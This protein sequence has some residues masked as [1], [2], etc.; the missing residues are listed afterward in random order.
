MAIAT[1]TILAGSVGCS[2]DWKKICTCV[3]SALVRSKS[4]REVSHNR[5]QLAFE[6]RSLQ[7]LN[8]VGA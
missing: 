6:S 8:W 7:T 3:V 1:R 5:L 4:D 2:T